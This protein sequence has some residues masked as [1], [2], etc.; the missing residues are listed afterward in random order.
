MEHLPSE[1]GPNTDLFRI[2]TGDVFHMLPLY[3]TSSIRKRTEHRFIPDTYWRRFLYVAVVWNIFHPKTD[4]TPIYSGYLPETFSTCCR[5]MEHLPSENGPQHRF[6][7]ET[8]RR[9]FP[10]RIRLPDVLHVQHILQPIM[11]HTNYNIHN[12]T[13][14]FCLFWLHP[15]SRSAIKV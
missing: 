3:G 11:N 13:V 9:R 14:K 1:N 10:P 6:I 12:N 7:P 8:S 5:F 4:R 15:G 2:P